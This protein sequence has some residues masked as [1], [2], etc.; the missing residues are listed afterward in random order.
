LA[1]FVACSSESTSCSANGVSSAMPSML[2][3]TLC[4][5]LSFFFFSSF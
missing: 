3:S 1:M 2:F 4:L 5:K